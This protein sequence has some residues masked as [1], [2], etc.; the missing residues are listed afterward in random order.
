MKRT[1]L[2]TL[3]V[4]S[5][6]ATS[7]YAS[8]ATAL[9]QAQK[10]DLVFMYQEEK[11][12]RDAYMTLGDIYNQKV[13]TNIQKSEQRHMDKVKGLLEAYDIPVP[14]IED[15][16]G[17]FENEDLQAL[18]DALVAQGEESLEEALKVGVAI[19]ETDIADLEEREVD[20]PDDVVKVFDSL[21]KG[22]HNHLNAF[23]RQLDKLD[24]SAESTT[25]S[26]NDKKSTKS[27]KSKK[28][29]KR[30]GHRHHR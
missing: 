19:E 10:D 16:V 18:Y 27:K 25:D 1:L 24:D 9:T 8:T 14:V 28:N 6:I 23:N 4:S 20:A 7:S 2:G 5:I 29:N 30:R 21:L 22:S 13:F 17:V 15:T 12:A 11:V 3:L 26:V